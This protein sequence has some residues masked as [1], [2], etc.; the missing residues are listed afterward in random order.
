MSFSR[1]IQ[2]YHSHVDPIW[3]DG[4]FKIPSESLFFLQ[5]EHRVAGGRGG[6]HPERRGGNP[7]LPNAGAGQAGGRR[8]HPLLPAHAARGLGQHP[9]LPAA[10]R[11]A[12]RLRH[13]HRLFCHTEQPAGPHRLRGGSVNSLC[14]VYGTA[15]NVYPS[16][17]C[18]GFNAD[19]PDRDPDP[20]LFCQCGSGSGSRSRILMTKKWK[21][22]TAE[23]KI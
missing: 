9:G 3:P 8:L 21:K 12:A 13:G 4:T 19:D 23:N 1:P 15:L 10:F 5:P 14:E 2:W 22:F 16:R 18:C 11:A 7:R 20:A 17:Q 6:P